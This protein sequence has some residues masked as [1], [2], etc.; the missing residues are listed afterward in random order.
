M[1]KYDWPLPRISQ[2]IW[3]LFHEESPKNVA[4][5]MYKEALGIFNY[6]ATFSQFS[7][8]PLT[9]QYLNSKNA[10][11]DHTYFMPVSR[12]NQIQSEEQLASVLFI[13]SICNTMSGRNQYIEELMKFIAIDS[14]GKCLN[15]KEIPKRYTYCFVYLYKKWNHTLS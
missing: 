1:N 9:L 7:S 11:L 13:Q 6:T 12:K 3:A 4:Y 5:L 8:F 2:H 14:Y 15:N 10:L